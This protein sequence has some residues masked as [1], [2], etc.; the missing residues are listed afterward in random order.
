MIRQMTCIPSLIY[1]SMTMHFLVSLVE[2][3]MDISMKIRTIPSNQSCP[4][5]RLI[6]YYHIIDDIG[7][8]QN[9]ELLILRRFKSKDEKKNIIMMTIAYDMQSM[10]YFHNGSFQYNVHQRVFMSLLHITYPLSIEHDH[11]SIE[12][13]TSL[14]SL[15]LNQ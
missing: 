14:N 9:I 12:L 7:M 5:E 4:F 10:Q 8:F 3:S 1:L 2:R 6:S 13:H 11:Q 15:L